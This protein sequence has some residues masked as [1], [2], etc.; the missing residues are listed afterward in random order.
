MSSQKPDTP[1]K[2]LK[3]HFERFHRMTRPLTGKPVELSKAK[4][5]YIPWPFQPRQDRHHPDKKTSFK[6]KSCTKGVQSDFLR[7]YHT[8]ASSSFGFVF[9]FRET[10]TP[11]VQFTIKADDEVMGFE[12]MSVDAFRVKMN[13]L[14]KVLEAKRG[15]TMKGLLDAL[16]AT[17][18]T[19]E[20]LDIDQVVKEAQ[21][22]VKQL[23][24]PVQTDLLREKREQQQ[25]QDSIHAAE[26]SWVKQ[27]EALPET[28]RI[29]ELKKEL[30]ELEKQQEAKRAAIK[31]DLCINQ[32]KRDLVKRREVI[33]KL[34]T[35][36]EAVL[37]KVKKKNPAFVGPR[38]SAE[39]REK[40]WW[41]NGL[42]GE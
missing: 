8:S 28:K 17:F 29:R 10:D 40:A 22:E 27:V 5:D 23:A 1:M 33:D 24:K 14:L 32:L 35:K 42:P 13:D 18:V 25:L 19:D 9:T 30:A 2:R 20:A 11:T 21:E 41:K 4:V 36:R 16:H 3:D 15:L 31:K 12:P 38:I 34:A 37:T 26:A 39:V 6:R 7:F